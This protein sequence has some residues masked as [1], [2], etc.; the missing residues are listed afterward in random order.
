M[1]NTLNNKVIEN[2]KNAINIEIKGIEE[3]LKNLDVNFCDVVEAILQTKGKVVVSGMGKSGIIGAKIAATF[4]STGTSSFFMHPAEAFHGDLGMVDKNDILLMLSC[5]GETEE[6]IRLLPYAKEN[7]IFVAS[8]TG[9]K[10]S[11][12]AVNSNKHI[13]INIPKEACPLKLAPTTSTT[14]TLV[15]GDAIAIALMER[16]N[17]KP[18]NF[19]KFH[20]G[21]SLG[22]KL[23]LKVADVMTV[24]DLPI[25]KL[26]DDIFNLIKVMTEKNTGVVVVN[27]QENKI[28]GV[29]S[30]GDMLRVLRDNKEYSGILIKNIMTKN[31]IYVEE[32]LSI[33]RAEKIM[34]KNEVTC[35]LIKEDFR[36]KG[37][38]QAS[39]C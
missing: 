31:P 20:P 18:E 12:L 2:A 28:I 35:L 13:Y 21:G 14:V 27:D 38:L 32:S 1:R 34:K 8:I 11:T 23:L 37:I 4:S 39:K 6:I 3:L 25:I 10:E 26:D 30:S 16:R 33:E 17:F 19:A 9:N 24:S 7:G 15:L 29:V 36:L 5:S 22:R